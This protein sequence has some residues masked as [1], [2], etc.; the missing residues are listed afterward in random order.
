MKFKYSGLTASGTA[1][2]EIRNGDIYRDKYGGTV[3]IKCVAERRVTYRRDGYGYDCVMPVYQ[4]RRDFSLVQTAPHNVPTSNAR[5]RA[6]IQKLKTMINGFR[7][8]K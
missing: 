1:R 2:P 5:A 6:N 3:T 7:G 4:F 8:K